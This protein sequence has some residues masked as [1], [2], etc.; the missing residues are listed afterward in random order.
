L[1]RNQD[2]AF[3]TP[4]KP[5]SSRPI[6]AIRTPAEQTDQ[7]F[8]DHK[9]GEQFSVRRLRRQLDQPCCCVED[10]HVGLSDAH[11]AA[12]VNS[13]QTVRKDFQNQLGDFA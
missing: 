2:I 6:W 11:G 3:A 9:W 10:V 4:C 13:G 7:N 1:V 12:L 8:I 5:D